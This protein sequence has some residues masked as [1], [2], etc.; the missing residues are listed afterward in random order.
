MLAPSLDTVRLFIH[1]L[2]ASVWVGGQI[3]LAGVVPGLREIGGDATKAA[4]NGFAAVAWPAFVIALFTGMWNI[5]DIDMAN[6]DTAYHMTLGVKFLLFI[7][8]GGSAFAHSRTSSPAMRG[9]TGG[10]GAVASIAVLFLG[11]LMSNPS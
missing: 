10:V 1:V 2:A 6:A 3:V 8:A 7:A 11:V 4:A 5:F 9:V